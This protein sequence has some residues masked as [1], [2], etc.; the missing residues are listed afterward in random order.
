MTFDFT[1]WKSRRTGER[2]ARIRMTYYVSREDL[3]HETQ[4]M[5]AN[6]LTPTKAKVEQAVRDGYDAHGNGYPM[7]LG[8]S[9]YEIDETG[10]HAAEAETLVVQFWPEVP[11]T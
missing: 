10:E 9:L 2:V 5:L 11:P 8:D 7:V 4:M 6:G 1:R 3:V